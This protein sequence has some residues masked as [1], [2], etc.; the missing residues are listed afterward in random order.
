MT[1]RKGFSLVELVI[2]V[3][4]LGVIA[5]IAIP[6]ISSGSKNAGESALKANL[7]TIRNAI[8]WY[9]GDHNF[10]YPGAKSD[11]VN[12]ASSPEA[13]V[14]QLIE[15][16]KKTGEVSA[17]KDSAYPYGPYIRGTFPALPVGTNSGKNTVSVISSAA[18]LT[19]SPGD[20]TG[21]VYNVLTGQIIANS[22][23]TGNDGVAFDAY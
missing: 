5:A 16:S 17:D 7:A 3:V 23:D 15:Y 8:D 6:R 9:Y 21:W 2:V 1:R 12:A 10:T 4:I 11:G 14:S 19:S 22:S 13:F 18:P 20:G